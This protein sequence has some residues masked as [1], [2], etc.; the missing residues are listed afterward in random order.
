MAVAWSK[1][2]VGQ[3]SGDVIVR[4][5]VVLTATLP[6]FLLTGD[7]RRHAARPR[8]CRRRRPA[9]IASPSARRVRS[10]SAP[11]RTQTMTA[12]RQAA[13]RLLAAD[14]GVRRRHRHGRGPRHR[15]ERL[16]PRAQLHAGR[17]AGDAGAD[18]AH[19]AAARRRARAS[20]CRNDLFADLV[21]RHRQRRGL[22][23]AIDRARRRGAAAGARPLSVRLLRA[24]HQ[25]RDAAALRQRTRDRAAARA[26]HGRRPAHPRRDRAA[27]RRGKART[28]RS[29][30]GR[31]AATMPGS[32]PT[33]PTS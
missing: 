17:Q 11:A 30:C 15:A 13:Q 5:P 24:D 21:P 25:P 8:Q 33:S 32:T 3:A 22:G 28:A 26:R 14:H 27:A 12:R 18:A 23:R 9:T 29:A 4:D 31:P 7:Q 6:R 1:D 19:R 10:R 20:R 2:K 16:R